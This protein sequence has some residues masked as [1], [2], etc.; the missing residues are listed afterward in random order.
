ML[1]FLPTITLLHIFPLKPILF[2]VCR[3]RQPL[4]TGNYGGALRRFE[5]L[6]QL[7]EIELQEGSLAGVVQASKSMVQATIV[8]ASRW[9]KQGKTRPGIGNCGAGVRRSKVGVNTLHNLYI[10][11]SVYSGVNILHFLYV[12]LVLTLCEARQVKA[13]RGREVNTLARQE[14]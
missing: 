1:S 2:L 7:V 8:Q 10:L 9:C 14:K 3:N 11:Y 4:H 13:Q 5:F 6:G 12:T